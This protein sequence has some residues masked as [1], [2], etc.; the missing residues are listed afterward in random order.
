MSTEQGVSV[1]NN[2][3]QTFGTEAG[4]NGEVRKATHQRTRALGGEKVCVTASK[5]TAYTRVEKR[6]KAFCRLSGKPLC[7]ILQQNFRIKNFFPFFLLKLEPL[8][9]QLTLNEPFR[10]PIGFL[11]YTFF[12][13]TKFSL[14]YSRKLQIS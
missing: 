11:L 10:T 3:T 7:R 2:T 12:C 5:Y 6:F 9:I 14:Y 4:V 13:K 1:P 8:I